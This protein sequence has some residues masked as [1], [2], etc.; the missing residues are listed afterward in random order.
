[1]FKNG[2]LYLLLFTSTLSFSQIGGKSTY[3][4]LSLVTSPRQA[5]LGGKLITLHD[6]DVNQAIYNPA[7]INP[8]MD[9]HLSVNYGSY[10]GEVTYGTAAYAY[11]YDRHVQTFHAGVSYVNYGTFEGRDEAGLLTGDFTGSEIALSFG[12]AYNIPWTDIY[13]GANAK[14][15][16]STLESYNSFGGAIDLGALYIDEDNDINIALAIR[17]VGT[18]FTT[19]AGLQEKLPLEIIAGISQ[20]VE[21]VPIRWHIT[22]ENLQQWNIA[23]SNPN[24]AEQSIDGS[25][26]EEKVSFV[27]NA[28][29]HLIMGAE[30][31]PGKSFNLR[32]GYNF[33]RGEEL[34]IEEQRNF[35]GIS[36]GMGL[37]FNNMRFDY[38]YSRYTL[39]ANT[40]LFGLMINLQ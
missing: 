3:Q 30:L 37:R 38:S 11:T 24:R 9:N 34:R 29:R 6:Y 2:Y 27:N 1:M 22:L 36:V 32:V 19:Y 16:S 40:S 28:L 33:R 7:T 13:V 8:E 18:Q 5:A 20:E 35:S 26:E 12:Y 4:F 21:N 15:I 31:F 39:A 14:M 23:F 25:T 17:N 10:F